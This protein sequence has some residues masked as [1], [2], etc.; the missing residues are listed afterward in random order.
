MNY[1]VADSPLPSTENPTDGLNQTIGV[2][3]KI[4]DG[5]FGHK[6]ICRKKRTTT[7]K[8]GSDT[9]LCLAGEEIS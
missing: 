2:D 5:V 8:L 1:F 7:V 3:Q 4:R 6:V 9:D